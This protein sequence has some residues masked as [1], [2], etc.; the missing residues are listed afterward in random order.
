MS[1]YSLKDVFPEVIERQSYIVGFVVQG[2]E[3]ARAYAQAASETGTDI[4][5]QA[6]PD[7]RKD[8]SIKIIAKMFQKLSEE[9]SVKIVSHLDHGESAEI[10]GEALDHGFSSVMFDG[11]RLPLHSNIA[12]TRKICDLALK[13]NASVEAELGFVGYEDPRQNRPTS[14]EEVELFTNSV[15]IDALAVSVG[16][17][18]L[19]IQTSAKV[20][21]GLLKDINAASKVPLVIHGGSGIPADDRH[22]MS[23]DFGVK[24]INIGTEFR[25]IFSPT[26]F[27]LLEKNEDSVDRFKIMNLLSLEYKKKA[28]LLLKGIR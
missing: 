18:H 25:R 4:I 28:E 8:M 1:K 27:D 16:N 12:E 14:P 2:W 20:D 3:D 9:S 5:L 6:G 26:L 22:K 11:S 19:Q 7:F 15:S 24:K 23:R 17:T 21:F 10:C 13:T